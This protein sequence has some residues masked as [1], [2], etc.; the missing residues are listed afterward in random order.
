MERF[1]NLYQVSKT[2]RFELKPVER[3]KEN[4]E[5]NGILE[6]DNQ[7]ALGYKAI[8]KVIDE[9]HKVFIDQM[10]DNF[11]LNLTDNGNLDS[12]E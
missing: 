10:L 8:K 2:L 12:L 9:Y 6:R 4:I 5:R 11:E 3:S 1:T 7:R